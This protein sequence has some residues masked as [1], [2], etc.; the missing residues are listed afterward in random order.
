[1]KVIIVK[2]YEELCQKGFEIMS[3]LITKKPDCT[4]GLATG[5]TPVGLYKKMVEANK[6]GKLDFSK[7]SSYNLD[8]YV[9]I[10]YNHPESYHK[11]MRRNLFD[12]VNIDLAKTHVPD[13]GAKDSKKAIDEYNEMLSKAT[14]DMQLLGIGSDGH[15]GFD[16]PGTPFDSVTHIVDLEESTIKD[17]ARFFDN[18]LNKVPR[19][20]MTMGLKNIMD[21]KSVLLLASGANKIDAIYN[22]VRGDISTDCPA[23]ILQNHP[24]CTIIVDEA[25]AAKLQ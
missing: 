21:A 25:A 1:M 5:G 2:N 15:I 12:H 10:D 19:K 4:L 9:G 24:N 20:A 11:F 23:S 3:E 22:T 14:I 17:N 13:G 8:E 16:E 6:A 7:V 18:D